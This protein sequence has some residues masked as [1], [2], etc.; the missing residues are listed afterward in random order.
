MTT[1]W[2]SYRGVPSQGHLYV[3]D[4]QQQKKCI[5]TPG[6][7]LLNLESLTSML[8]EPEQEP[9]V[10]ET[11]EVPETADQVPENAEEIEAELED[12]IKEAE[13][14]DEAT[15]DHNEGQ[16]VEV[17]DY[18]GEV[19]QVP[20]EGENESAEVPNESV[21]EE[22]EEA[23]EEPNVEERVEDNLGTNK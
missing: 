7:S 9:E 3:A 18:D 6:P 16:I 14:L 23:D 5:F 20:N 2:S 1:K 15:S 11:T 12:Q 8:Q 10:P 21:P 19:T 17:P 22:K 13:Q 4:Q